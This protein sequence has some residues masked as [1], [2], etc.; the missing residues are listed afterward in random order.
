MSHIEKSFNK[1]IT[2]VTIDLLPDVIPQGY[3]CRSPDIRGC[4]ISHI[5]VFGPS[6]SPWSP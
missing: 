3:I 2:S 6:P 1:K 4:E 5:S